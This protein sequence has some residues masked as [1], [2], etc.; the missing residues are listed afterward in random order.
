MRMKDIK[1]HILRFLGNYFLLHIIN[2]LCKTYRLNIINEKSVAELREKGENFILAF[3]HGTML[4]PWYKHRDM[5]MLGL[6]S[7]SKDGEILARILRKWN[8]TVTR[9]SSSKGG[10][11]SLGVMV[12]FAK[13]EGSV[14][15]TP[16][17]PRG[18]RQ[19]LKAG[20]VIAAKKS[21]TPLVLLGV[22]YQSK[23]V[24]KS[25]D[26]FEIPKPFTKVNLVYSERIKIPVDSSYDQTSVIIANCN[27]KLIRLQSEAERFPI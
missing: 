15:I 3:W 14:C 5:R 8:Y 18:P 9:G 26:K 7:Q 24:L 22:G 1:S 20:A 6:I 21:G 16:D 12:D 2:L 13:F 11:V 27:E 4:V 19:E 23:F 25:W 17:G 10:D